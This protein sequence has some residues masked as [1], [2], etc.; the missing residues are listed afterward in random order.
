MIYQN[1]DIDNFAYE[2]PP[3]V[4]SSEEIENRLGPVYERLGLPTGRLELMSGIKERR[5]WPQGSTPSYGAILAGRKALE[6]ASVSRDRIGCLINC[7]VSRDFLEPA[8]ATVVHHSLD[9]PGNCL[10]FDISNACLGILSGMIVLANMIENG[11]VEA[12]LLVA[13]ENCRSLVESTINSLL[14]D[15]TVT[16]RS[17]KPYFASLTIG[18]G[19]V[20]VVMTRRGLSNDGHRLR[21]EK[22][23]AATEYNNLCQGNADKG[24][25]DDSVTLMNTDS[26]TL[27]HRGVDAALATWNDFRKEN[28]LTA[29]DFDCICTHQVGNAHKKLLFE[30]LDLD[31]AKDYSTLEYMG[32]VGSVSCPLTVAM[33]E[34]AKKIKSGERLAM[35]GIGSGINCTM[36]G[37]EW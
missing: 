17:I 24:M 16:R 23:L 33:A 11:Q 19:S 10:V 2:L 32:N 1:V 12:G 37:V 5:F 9:L 34:E 22:T 14:N 4:I 18:S 7:S 27:M 25:N 3:E 8:T 6:R 36:L 26:E 31:L 29:S 21:Y 28:S 20:A 13:G 30:R 35:L 15:P